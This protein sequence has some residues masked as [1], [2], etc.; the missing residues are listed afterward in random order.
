[1]KKMGQWALTVFI[2]TLLYEGANDG[3]WPM[4]E[5]FQHHDW[6]M[7]GMVDG[8]ISSVLLPFLAAYLLASTSRQQ[9]L[10]SSPWP[11]LLAP[12][13]LLVS[14]KYLADAFYPPF[15]SEFLSDAGVGA[16]Q[17]A[18]AMAG[19]FLHKRVNSHQAIAAPI[20]AA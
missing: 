15:W 11:F 8:A 3:L 19:W 12:F 7:P 4:I 6:Q 13:M 20:A 16:I 17:G 2:Y 10:G 9:V 1:M 18:S 14:A 5:H